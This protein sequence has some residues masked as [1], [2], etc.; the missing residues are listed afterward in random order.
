MSKKLIKAIINW[1]LIRVNNN[2]SR[3]Y[4]LIII[5]SPQNPLLEFLINRDNINLFNNQI[6]IKGSIRI[7]MLLIIREFLSPQLEPHKQLPINI[8]L[9]LQFNNNNN[10][11][12]DMYLDKSKIN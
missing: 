1:D 2:I 3:N 8:I 5:L 10:N 9:M 11:L 6:N 4:L 7:T 12:L